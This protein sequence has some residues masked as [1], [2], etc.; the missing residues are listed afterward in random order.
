MKKIS[1][2]E[3]I[4]FL[5][6]EIR[7]LKKGVIT[8]FYPDPF[9]V[10]LWCQYET[11]FYIHLDNTIFF[12]R[13][14]P[15]FI[16]L[17]YCSVN[18]DS[19]RQD[20][21]FLFKEYNQSVFVVDLVGK[22]P[23][24]DH[25]QLFFNEGFKEYSSLVRMSRVGSPVVSEMVSDRKVMEATKQDI[26]YLA[27]LYDYYFDPYI[28][29]IP[30]KEELQQWI[31]SGHVLLCRK[32]EKIAGFLIYDLIGV[33]L[34]LRYWFVLP[35]FRDCGI[36]ATL[37][38]EFFNRGKDTKRQLFW[39]IISNKNAIKRYEHYGFTQEKMF[40]YVLINK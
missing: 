37:F 25:R 2:F 32:D 14:Q 21:S 18:E 23:M 34:Y 29:Q 30:L 4:Q 26:P 5:F 24:I 27:E 3:E 19:L 17:F 20:L 40:D 22:D 11:L 10:S 7:S 12:L 9:R 38:H 15:H 36:G 39:V 28:E 8:N 31:E 6:S 16:N 1:S 35:E 13:N 33:T